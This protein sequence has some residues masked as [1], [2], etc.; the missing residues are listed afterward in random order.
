ML[1]IPSM[2]IDMEMR[3]MPIDRSKERPVRSWACL[4]CDR[5]IVVTARLDPECQSSFSEIL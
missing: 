5:A 4:S 2:T 1:I 3:F